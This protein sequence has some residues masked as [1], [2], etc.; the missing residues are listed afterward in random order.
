M[1]VPGRWIAMVARTRDGWDNLQFGMREASAD[2]PRR[3]ITTT[4]RPIPIL[5]KIIEMPTTVLVRGSSHENARNFDPS[6]YKETLASYE[7]TR[8]GRQEI[9][10]EILNDVPG[11]LWTRDILDKALMRGQLPDM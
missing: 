2:R 3:L 6:W 8:I 9:Y 5:Q 11:A 7:G 10:A 1:A 4:P